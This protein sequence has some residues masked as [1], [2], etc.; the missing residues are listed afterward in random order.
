MAAA[1]MAA[2][3]EAVD[4]HMDDLIKNGMTLEDFQRA[5]ACGGFSYGD[6]LGAGKG[7]ANSILFNDRL[8]DEFL[9]FFMMIRNLLWEYVIGLPNAIKPKKY[10]SWDP[11]LVT[12]VK[13]IQIN[14]KRA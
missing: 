4:V 5:A 13:I 11:I 12:F 3:F 14:L 7:W 6:V 10:Y 1:F 8:N 2:G 9:S